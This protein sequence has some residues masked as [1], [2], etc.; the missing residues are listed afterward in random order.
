VVGVRLGFVFIPAD[1]A[2]TARWRELSPA[3]G[4]PPAGEPKANHRPAL[5]GRAANA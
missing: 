5:G 4:T 1:P 2:M 3:D